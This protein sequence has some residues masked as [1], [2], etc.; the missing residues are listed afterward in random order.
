MCWVLFQIKKNAKKRFKY[1]VR[2]LRRQQDHIK[3]EQLGAALS[4]SR[5]RDFLK[6]VRNITKS[7]IGTS[8]TAPNVDNCS[9]DVDIAN[10]YGSK[11]QD[12][13]NSDKDAACLSSLSS[14]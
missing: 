12:L 6:I 14:F 7:I 5:Q 1:E 10:L 8:S 3:R 4:Q 9:S 13:L 2:R 11:L